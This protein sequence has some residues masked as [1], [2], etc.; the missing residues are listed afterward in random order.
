[1]PPFSLS[2]N[3]LPILFDYAVST[4]A[5]DASVII[6]DLDLSCVLHRALLLLLLVRFFFYIWSN[7]L[8]SHF[9]HCYQLHRVMFLCCCMLQNQL[10][11]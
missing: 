8:T 6:A 1:M 10:T 5:P 2:P 4:I 11:S 9:W 7:S 3:S